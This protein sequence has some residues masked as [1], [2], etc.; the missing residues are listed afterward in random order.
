MIQNIV[1]SSSSSRLWCEP[2]QLLKVPHSLEPKFRCHIYS[3]T[4]T[5]S[6]RITVLCVHAVYRRQC[7]AIFHAGP[8]I[9]EEKVK[10][11][12]EEEEARCGRPSWM[13]LGSK[14]HPYIY[15]LVLPCVH[16]KSAAAAAVWRNKRFV[17]LGRC[18]CCCSCYCYLF[19]LLLLHLPFRGHDSP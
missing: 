7:D 16:K 9:E 1:W 6:P 14:R 4:H 5:L 15:T 2:A 18:C 11:R 12:E 13:N 3:R 10:R 17:S 8:Q 19:F